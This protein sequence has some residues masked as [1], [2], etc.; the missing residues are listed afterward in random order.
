MPRASCAARSRVRTKEAG[1]PA[2]LAGWLAARSAPA[3]AAPW[4]PSRA[5]SGFRKAAI[6]A[7]AITTATVISAAIGD[8]S[9]RGGAWREPGMTHCQGSILQPIAG[10]EDPPHHDHAD[11]QRHQRDGDASADTDGG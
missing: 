1:S 9:F 5:C 7:V 2:P 10:L 3:S 6:A 4:A 11:R 8:L